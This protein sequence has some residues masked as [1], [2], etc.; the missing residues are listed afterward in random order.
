LSLDCFPFSDSC[1]R[2]PRLITEGQLDDQLR[3]AEDDLA[4]LTDV[5]NELLHDITVKEN[6]KRIDTKCVAARKL[7]AWNTASSRH[8][9]K[10]F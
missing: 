6:S 9:P 8:S 3:E 10:R 7:T 5:L 1:H 4:A 2:T